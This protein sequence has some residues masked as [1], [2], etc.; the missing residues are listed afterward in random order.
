[1]FSG[2]R[3]GTTLYILDKSKEPKVVTGYVET[4]TAPRPMYKNYNPA[5]SFGANLQTVV[6]IVVKVDNE[7]KEFVGIPS[8]NT[9]HSYGDYVLSETR[10]GMIQEVDAMLQ[11]SKNVVASM[12]QHQ[13]NIKAC[14]DILK[15]LNPI[16]AKESE[17]DEAI[18]S[19]TKQVDSMQS[20]L[21][22]LESLI[23]RQNTDGN[24][25]GI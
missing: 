3:Q 12:D 6:D 21:T 11:N 25:Q 19:L 5:V 10:E 23:T 8:T 17:R 15:T 16:Y 14:E 20:V 13:S 4:I 2:L 18:D 22:R 7:K 24:N 1:M 9:I